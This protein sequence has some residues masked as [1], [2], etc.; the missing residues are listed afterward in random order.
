MNKA[1]K[2]HAVSTKIYR[3][4]PCRVDGWAEGQLIEIQLEVWCTFKNDLKLFSTKLSK[5]LSL[6]IVVL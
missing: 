4:S 5:Q 3:L 6:F 1:M 2:T